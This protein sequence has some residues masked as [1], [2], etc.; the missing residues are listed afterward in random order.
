MKT[1]ILFLAASGIAS[2]IIA[3]LSLWAKLPIAPLP[4][5]PPRACAKVVLGPDWYS[6]TPYP[7]RP[8]PQCLLSHRW[9]ACIK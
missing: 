8:C 6:P 4:A 3:S 1:R 7:K 2:V 5:D 9:G